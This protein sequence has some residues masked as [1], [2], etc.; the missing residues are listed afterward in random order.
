MRTFCPARL[1]NRSSPG[2]ANQLKG[3]CHGIFDFWFFHESVS[4]KA[5]SILLGPFRI[6]SKIR[7]DIYKTRYTTGINDTGAWQND[8]IMFFQ[9]LGGKVIHEKKPEAKY[10]VTLSL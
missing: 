7:G 6:L 2:T 4:P 10:L 5:L 8:P 9:G 3:Q 1:S